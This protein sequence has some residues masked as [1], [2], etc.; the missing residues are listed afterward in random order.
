MLERV[1]ANNVATA[2]IRGIL[3]GV[4]LRVMGRWF[5]AE[6]EIDRTGAFGALL[7]VRSAPLRVD[8]ARKEAM[9]DAMSFMGLPIL[10]C[11]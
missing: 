5:I 4:A 10:R 6:N 11:L 2:K 1:D 8:A 3:L 9:S 7:I